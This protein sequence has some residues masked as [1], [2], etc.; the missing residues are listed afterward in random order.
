MEANC[1]RIEKS[2]N[3]YLSL[4]YK[5]SINGGYQI[6]CVYVEAELLKVLMQS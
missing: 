3:A 4:A 6:H 1:V 5:L 2:K